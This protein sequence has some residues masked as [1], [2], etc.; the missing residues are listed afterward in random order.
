[1]PVTLPEAPELIEPPPPPPGVIVDPPH[2]FLKPEPRPLPIVEPMP[3]PQ[4][5]IPLWKL[6]RPPPSPGVIVEPPEELIIEP[7]PPGV[8]I[9]PMPKPLPIV[10][11]MPHTP[12]PG[13]IIEPMPK[14]LP[15]VEPMPRPPPPGVI[16]EPMP[17]P[18]PIVE[19]MP[20]PPPPG[21]IVEPPELIIEPDTFPGKP[22]RVDPD[23][24][25][26]W[27][28][29]HQGLSDAGE[30]GV[31]N[32]E[33]LRV[34][35]ISHAEKQQFA[36]DLYTIE[37]SMDHTK[38]VPENPDFMKTESCPGTGGMECTLKVRV[39]KVADTHSFEEMSCVPSEAPFI[40][41]PEIIIEP[42]PMIGGPV[43]FDPDSDEAWDVLQHGLESTDM[44]AGD[45]DEQLR[46]LKITKAEQLFT[47]KMH[48][49]ISARLDYT[50]CAP[51][52]PHFDDTAECPGVRGQR[53]E[54]NITMDGD[55]YQ[56]TGMGCVP[57][58]PPPPMR[59][60]D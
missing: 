14:P 43:Q 28:V 3:E 41:P 15:I 11:P 12:P 10:E 57:D 22:W 40:L 4:T 16:I 1:M 35:K 25:E 39:D 47:G 23:S 49:T 50:T 8:I 19:P 30:L 36:F 32:G 27:Q 7:P 52:D 6:E 21:V 31:K 29:A 55:D 54:V 34:L 56:A 58:A 2:R 38:C 18:Q 26:A 45:E 9:E 17:R 5:P 37:L 24:D 20:H 46:V 48:Y 59:P 51:E 42:P 33:Y 53:C 44:L 60:V 13:V